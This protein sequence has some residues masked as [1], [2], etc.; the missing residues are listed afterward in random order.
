MS[1]KSSALEAKV[2]H[3]MI[4]RLE[5]LEDDARQR[6]IDTISTFYGLSMTRGRSSSFES[7]A[8]SLSPVQSSE[9]QAQFSN[10]DDIDPKEFMRQKQPHTDVERVA[11]LAFY[12]AHYRGVPHFK[13]LDISKLNT[14]AAQPKFSNPSVAVN[15]AVKTGYL[16]DAPKGHK[17]ISAA[18]EQ[19][20]LALPD[21]DQAKQ[22][23]A[24]AR[25]KRKKRGGAGSKKA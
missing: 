11:C 19:F 17:Q 22:A 4:T 3:D 13:T 9:S 21:R 7:G 10:H 25:A 24:R 18:G 12:L 2:L 5:V 20:V 6:L 16:A 8:I 14:D 15:N 23:M 1:D